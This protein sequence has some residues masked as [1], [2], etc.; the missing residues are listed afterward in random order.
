MYS[1]NTRASSHPT[2]QCRR[3]RRAGI[4]ARRARQDRLR[5]GQRAGQRRGGGQAAETGGAVRRR[6][7]V[8]QHVRQWR[9]REQQLRRAAPCV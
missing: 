7:L 1:S 8:V 2:C 3:Q 4:G 6:V 5:A 9:R